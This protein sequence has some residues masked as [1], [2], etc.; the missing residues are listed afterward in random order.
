[1]SDYIDELV[2]EHGWDGN[3]C[4][5]IESAV[6]LA[7]AVAERVKECARVCRCLQ[8]GPVPCPI[9]RGRGVTFESNTTESKE[10]K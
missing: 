2:R 6:D 8:H 1:M 10:P 9:C 5:P 3:V 7:R 4:L